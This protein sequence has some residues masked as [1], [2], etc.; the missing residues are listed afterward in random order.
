MKISLDH[1]CDWEHCQLNGDEAKPCQ[2]IELF[3]KFQVQLALLHKA[4]GVD[5]EKESEGDV[6]V[7]G[8]VRYGHEAT[9]GLCVEIIMDKS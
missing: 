5:D 7:E 2:P 6:Q 4:I 8:D 1:R 3:E 9:P